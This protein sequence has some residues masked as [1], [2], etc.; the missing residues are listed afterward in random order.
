MRLTM[1]AIPPG[2]ATRFHGEKR[3]A[4][5]DGT[6]GTEEEEILICE[7]CAICGS[8]PPGA[9]ALDHDDFQRFR[10]GMGRQLDGGGGLRERKLVRDE[11]ARVQLP[12][13]H[14]PRHFRLQ[15]EIRRVAPDQVLL[16]HTHRRQINGRCARRAACGRTA[17]P[18]R[19]RGPMP[20]PPAPPRRT[21]PRSPPRPG[22]G[23]VW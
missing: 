22:P 17:A 16:I 23:P 12:R 9:F 13:E 18:G 1:A 6:D 3:R 8:F 21:A 19:R 20:A 2:Q 11:P 7:I 5:T 4:A 15:P 14:Q 10:G